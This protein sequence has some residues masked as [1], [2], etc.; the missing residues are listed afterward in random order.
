MGYNEPRSEAR[1]FIVVRGMYVINRRRLL[2]VDN[3]CDVPWRKFARD[4]FGDTESYFYPNTL[5][6]LAEL[7]LWPTLA[8]VVLKI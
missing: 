2:S 1:S 8:V 7:S 6:R 3:T 4:V 5:N